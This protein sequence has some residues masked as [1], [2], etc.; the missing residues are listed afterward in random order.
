MNELG[1]R[2]DTDHCSDATT[3]D[4]IEVSE[5][6][7]AVSHSFCRAVSEHDRGKGDDVIRAV[8]QNG[9]YF[10]VVL[11]PF[12]ITGDPDPSLDHWLAHV[13]HAVALAGPEHVG[14]GTDWGEELP[15]QLVDLLNEEIRQ[16]GF[17]FRE[18]HRV[19]WAA[20]VGGY[21]SW[22]EWPNLTRALAGAGYSDDE[23]RG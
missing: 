14:I 19:D 8:G 7:V 18:E 17:G 6:P 3:L 20:T 4:A 23:I 21:G 12:F 9:G 5:R 2:V 15:K 10:G 13:E 16:P 22:R 11:V 1:I